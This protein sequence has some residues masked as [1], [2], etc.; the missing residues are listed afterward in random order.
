MFSMPIFTMLKPNRAGHVPA[1]CVSFATL[2]AMSFAC[3]GS[4]EI[5]Y[6]ADNAF[7]ATVNDCRN[8]DRI[9]E[10]ACGS[11]NEYE[12]TFAG[13]KLRMNLTGSPIWMV[14]EP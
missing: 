1:F 10:R 3:A 7:N 12:V 5:R 14:N 8:S 9:C 4:C 11:S 6:C 13:T 2:S